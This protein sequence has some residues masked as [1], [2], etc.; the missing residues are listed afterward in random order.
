MHPIAFHFGAL[1]IHWYGVMIALAF[2][3]GLWTAMLRAR[4]ENLPA[5]RIA[6]VVLW[7]MIGSI[8][9]A[10]IVYVTTYWKDEFAGQRWWEM[11]MIQQGGLVYYGGLIGAALAGLIYIR[12]K[13][14]PLWKTADVLAPS[15][16]LGNVFG[17]IGCFLNGCCFGRPAHVPWAVQ[18]PKHSYAWDTQLQQG[19]IGPGQPPLAVHPTEIYDS[20]NNFLLYL[21]LA[22]L[23]R[24]KK[25]DGQ[26]F[27]SYLVGYAVTRSF[28]EYFRGDY[29]PDHIHHGLT[30]GML[31]SI[32]TF[33]LGL[34]LGAILSRRAPA[35]PAT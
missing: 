1:T 12:W 34:M 14:L 33:V 24:R 16:A 21:L 11:F 18:F 29:P 13:K 25:F 17:R 3:A 2:L 19:L 22:W 8:L 7:L 27:A 20:V 35:R 32:P 23:F 31:V 30:P 4:R 5:E 28:M 15:C 9:G 10:R 26:V 6:D